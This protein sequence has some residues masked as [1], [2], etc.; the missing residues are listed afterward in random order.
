MNEFVSTVKSFDR[1][2]L[3]RAMRAVFRRDVVDL[4]QVEKPTLILC[5]Q[6]D[7]ATPV[8]R[9]KQLHDEIKGSQL[10]IIP[11]AGHLTAVEQPHLVAEKLREFL[12]SPT[13]DPV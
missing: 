11:D 5:G 13:A 7:S 4:R 1:K 10:R 2:Q 6:Y 3:G 12:S 8:G 9:H